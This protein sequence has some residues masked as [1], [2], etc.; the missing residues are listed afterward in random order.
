[1]QTI[2]QLERFSEADV[3]RRTKFGDLHPDGLARIDLARPV[4][5]RRVDAYAAAF[6]DYLS[7]F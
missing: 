2:D 4:V 3:E 5:E 6:S 1:M 7:I